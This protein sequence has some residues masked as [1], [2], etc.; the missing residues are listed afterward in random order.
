[1]KK[2]LKLKAVL[3]E[4]HQIS[5]HA[6]FGGANAAETNAALCTLVFNVA[7]HIFP[8]MEAQKQFIYDVSHALQEVWDKKGDVEE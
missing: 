1:M 6:V 5:C 3:Y 8:D 7:E 2:I 4:D